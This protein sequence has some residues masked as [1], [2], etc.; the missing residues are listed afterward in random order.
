MNIKEIYIVRHGETE[1]NRKGIVQGSGIDSNLNSNG[2]R[3]AEFFF[4]FYN[5]LHFD[6]V[7]ISNLIRT[8]QTVQLFLDEGM[9]FVIDENIREISW[10]K[11]EGQPY[12]EELKSSYKEM[13]QNWSKGNHYFSLPDGESLH[14]LISRL[15][16]FFNS[17]VDRKSVV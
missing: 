4:R 6:K 8:K 9:P 14:S 17:I 2:Y 16:F 1:Y 3:Q 15:K 5:H 10:G 13:V 7:F 12:S 11:F